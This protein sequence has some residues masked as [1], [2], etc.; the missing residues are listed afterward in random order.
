MRTTAAVLLGLALSSAAFGATTTPSKQALADMGLAGMQVMSDEEATS[1][2]GMGFDGASQFHAAFADF[3]KQVTAF[4][5]QVQDFRHD[6]ESSGSWK[7]NNMKPP[8]CDVKP[9]KPPKCDVKTPKM[10]KMPSGGGGM[11]Y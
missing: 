1:V 10:P 5:K 11:R 7:Q 6:I 8:K 4:E 2:R 9:P 3:Q